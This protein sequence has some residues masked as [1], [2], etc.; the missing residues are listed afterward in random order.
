MYK[1]EHEQPSEVRGEGN[2]EVGRVRFAGIDIGSEQHAVALVGEAGE[3]LQK[4]V[5]FGEEAAGYRRLPAL[6]GEPADCLVV[7]EATGH[8]WKNLVAWL[9]GE[10][11]AIALLN[12]IRTRRFAEEELQRIKTDQVDAVGIARFAA[13][14]RPAPTNFPDETTEELRQLVRLRLRTIQH[15][16]DRVRDLHQAIDLTFPEFTRHVRGLDT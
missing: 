14:K 10:D 13:R 16:G 5:S 1:H 3:V 15:L 9:V 7:I 11:F 4:P 12:P 2:E 8:Y 6:L